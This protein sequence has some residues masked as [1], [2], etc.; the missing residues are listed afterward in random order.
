LQGL[1]DVI[2]VQRRSLS[3]L[4]F[5]RARLEPVGSP[6]PPVGRSGTDAG[7][8]PDRFRAAPRSVAEWTILPSVSGEQA[9]RSAQEEV[10]IRVLWLV[11]GLGAGG[12]ERLLVLS[13]RHRGPGVAPVA[14][15]L[16]LAKNALRGPL[17]AAGVPAECLG[18]R[19]ALDLRWVLRL[20]RLL[21]HGDF[22]VVHVHSPI[23]AVGARLVRA[24]LP[25]SR[26]PAL[27]TTEH[28]VWGSHAR[29]TRL[30]DG[31][32]ARGCETHLAVSDA[33]RESLPRR[34]RAGT[35]VVRYGIEVAATVAR[36]SERAAARSG[37]GA[38]PD[39]LVV[40]TVA[41]LRATKGYP[42]LLEAA[43]VV[44]ERVPGS[45]FVA[46]GQGPLAEDLTTLRD[47]LG[48]GDR[49]SFLGYREDAPAVMA[50]FDVF[51]LASHH[52]GLPVALMEA[53]ALGL[54]VVA[55]TAGG[56]AELVSDGTDA[57]LVPPGRPAALAEAISGLLA[58]PDRRAALG[59]AAGA[60][61]ADLDV[62]RGVARVEA[63]YAEA[64]RR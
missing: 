30:L 42:D 43:R 41:N 60:H 4:R 48:L 62:T 18:V 24:T 15:Y 40:G 58:D 57:V 7:P 34:L 54:P 16:L 1:D 59:R 63:V 17:E 10:P 36:R 29:I 45:R 14:A 44:T 3:V 53:L 21:R 23:A 9:G 39:D 27:I 37:F 28:N 2:E 6:A 31:L 52:E 26:R 20:R 19:S 13:A 25:R 32:T 12:A 64:A 55:T 35:E 51:C 61:A 50:G 47:A 5:R 22:A 56:V 49:F 46:V 8:V 11:K 33:V 38:G